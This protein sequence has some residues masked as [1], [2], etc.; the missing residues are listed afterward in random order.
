MRLASRPSSRSSTH[1]PGARRV[2]HAGDRRLGL[3]EVVA[4]RHALAGRQAVGL[5][6]DP[7]AVGVERPR[8]RPAPA[9]ASGRTRPPRAIADAGRGRDL[10]AERLAA[11]DPG[12]GRGRPE[13]RDPGRGERV[14]DAGRQRRLRPDDDELDRVAPRERDDGG[15]VERIDVRR[16]APAARVAIAV[17]PRRDDRP[18]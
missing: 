13:D 14:G 11:L 12:R 9:S 16:G 8:R 7:R 5:D 17:A 18:R 3:V 1:D 10:V 4:D 15:P 6:D 2:Q